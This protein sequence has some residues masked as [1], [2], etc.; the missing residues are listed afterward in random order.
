MHFVS[1]Q[2]GVNYAV[3]HWALSCDTRPQ[4]I[5]KHSIA[6]FKK[7]NNNN[8]NNNKP[9]SLFFFAMFWYCV[10]NIAEIATPILCSRC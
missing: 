4:N 7:K 2:Y 1:K 3:K 10:S 6:K 9:F 5:L 8:N